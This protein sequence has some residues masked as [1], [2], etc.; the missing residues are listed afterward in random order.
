MLKFTEKNLKFSNFGFSNL[1]IDKNSNLELVLAFLVLLSVVRKLTKIL[2]G[3]K[4]LY[5]C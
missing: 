3:A 4:I 5:S 2:F 1:K